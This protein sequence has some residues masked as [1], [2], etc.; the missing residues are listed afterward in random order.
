M[1]NVTQ[2]PSSRAKTQIQACQ[3]LEHSCFSDNFNISSEA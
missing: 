1:P 3:S 2:L